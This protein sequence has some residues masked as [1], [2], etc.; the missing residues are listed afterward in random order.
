MWHVENQVRTSG[1]VFVATPADD[2][3]RAM[4][5]AILLQRRR[6]M[7]GLREGEEATMD[8]LPY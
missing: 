4:K 5:F 7:L 2:D 6:D 1:E 3:A 8:P